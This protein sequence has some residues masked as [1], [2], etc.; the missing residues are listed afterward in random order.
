[1]A[2]TVQVIL[3]EDVANLG[4][5]GEIVGVRPGYARNYLLPQRK[6]L[7]ADKRSVRAFEHQKRLT[8]HRKLKLRTESE[9]LAGDLKQVSVTIPAKAG[10]QDKLFGS[11]GARDIA[12]ALTGLGYPLS[13]RSVKLAEPIKALGQYSVDVRLQ[14]DVMTQVKVLVVPE[15]AEQSMTEVDDAEEAVVGVAPDFKSLTYY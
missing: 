9:K 13:H 2:R 11:V 4:Q 10:E 5:V 6:A 14:A 7:V 12:R 15:S 3:Q 1:M 8:E